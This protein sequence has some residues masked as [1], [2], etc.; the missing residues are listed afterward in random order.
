MQALLL[1]SHGSRK[2]Q[3]NEEVRRLSKK[4]AEQ[5]KPEFALTQC[6][7][8]ELATPSIPEGLEACIRSGAT[9]I[10]V[11]PYFLAT[12]RHVSEDIP[13]EIEKKRKEYPGIQIRLHNHVGSASDSMV[14]ALLKL[15]KE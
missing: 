9:Q 15:V 14:D 8:L 1:I 3:S 13:G 10:E 11:L 6:A 12:G 5:A 2:E 7:F 4:L